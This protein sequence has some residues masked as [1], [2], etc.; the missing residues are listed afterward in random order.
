V[1]THS[2]L[3][4]P[5][6]TEKFATQSEVPDIIAGIFLTLVTMYIF[7]SNNRWLMWKLGRKIPEAPKD[8]NED[9]FW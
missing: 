9:G 3:H 7:K 6:T 8:S 5:L 1:W 4:T 2:G